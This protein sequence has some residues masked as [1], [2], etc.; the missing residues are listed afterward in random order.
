MRTGVA[1]WAISALLLVVG[2]SA[3]GS[4]SSSD[5][6]VASKSADQIV[7][8][9]TSAANSLSSVHVAGSLFSG[10]RPITLDL[11]LVSGKGGRGQMSEGSLS[12]QLIN[13]D[14]VVYINGGPKFWRRFGGAAAAQLLQGRWLKAPA[15]GDFASI[16]TLT[17]LQQLFSKL[18]STHGAL[19]KSGTTTKPWS[20][21]GR[22]A[23]TSWLSWFALP[24]RLSASP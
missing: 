24:S 7:A 22:F 15:T 19:A 23:R 2:L 1:R 9:A 18:L 11:E 14:Q 16:T 3:C 10:G 20:A 13:V 6:G 4:S 12:F 5:N 17:N 8:A 21:A